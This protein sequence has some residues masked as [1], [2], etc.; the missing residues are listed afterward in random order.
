[1][2]M[3]SSSKQLPT[4]ISVVLISLLLIKNVSTTAHGVNLLPIAAKLQ[5][6]N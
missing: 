6:G 5:A 1:M 2:K 4:L 3:G